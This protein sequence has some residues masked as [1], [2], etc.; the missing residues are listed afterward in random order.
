LLVCPVLLA[1]LSGTPAGYED[2]GT[3]STARPFSWPSGRRAALS[4]TFDDARPSQVDV[5]LPILEHHG[6]RA[7]FYVTPDR[8]DA[9]LEGWKLAVRQG[10]EIGNHSLTHPCTGNFA[11]SRSNALEDYTLAQLDED[12]R[13]ATDAIHSRLGL[14]PVSFA[15]PCGQS[16]VGRGREARSYVPLIAERFESG[17]LWLS[18]DANDPAFCDPPQLLAME[19]DGKSFEQ[20]RPLLEAAVKQGKW[21]ILAGHEIGGGGRQTTLTNTLDAVC[22]FAADPA[23]G[24]WLDTVGAITR[25]VRTQRELELKP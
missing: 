16:F 22:A 4:L 19:F 15:Y 13:Q 1:P 10:H 23:N 20:I 21:L 5:G 6:A 7:T 12:L 14:K 3:P 18:E 24:L 9:R 25:H 8:L 2:R 17:R 11:F